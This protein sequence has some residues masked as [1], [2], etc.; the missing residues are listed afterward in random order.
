SRMGKK[1]IKDKVKHYQ[2]DLLYAKNHIVGELKIGIPHSLLEYILNDTLGELPKKVHLNWVVG[3]YLPY[4]YE[5]SFDAVIFCGALPMG[6]FYAKKVGTWKK[7]V[8]ASKNYLKE[9]Q[10]LDCPSALLSHDCLDHIDNFQSTWQLDQS[11]PIRITQRCSSSSLIAQMAENDLGLCYLPSFT[12]KKQLEAG[13]LVE[14][15]TPYTTQQFDIFMV[16]K[17]PIADTRKLALIHNF[18]KQCL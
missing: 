10:K 15:L 7:V 17:E 11:Y 8:C 5:K 4:L 12:V 13:D 3:N 9:H 14:V 16:T 2:N 18:F 6:D 1:H